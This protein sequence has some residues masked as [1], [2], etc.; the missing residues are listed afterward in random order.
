MTNAEDPVAAGF[1]ASLARP[2]RNV[3]ELTTVTR[4]LSAKRLEVLKDI[5]P[6]LSR[7][8]VLWNPDFPDKSV[9]LRETESA[10]QILDIEIQ[11]LEI[12]SSTDVD[13]I[14]EIALKARSEAIITLPDP[15]TNSSRTRIIE[16][17]RTNRL[18]TMF[19]QR[20]HVDAGGLV[21]YGPSLAAGC[22]RR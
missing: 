7:V 19:S 10:A 18:A 13:N 12:R 4:D 8:S 15:V 3:T 17:A 9:E 21:F 2:G 20:P 22:T 14:F 1:V 6:K 5:L 11:S 16:F